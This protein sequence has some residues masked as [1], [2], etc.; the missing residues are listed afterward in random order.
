MKRSPSA[1][2]HIHTPEQV[3]VVVLCVLHMCVWPKHWKTDSDRLGEWS[4]GRH[5]PDTT[6]CFVHLEVY[7]CIQRSGSNLL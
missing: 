3:N 7:K 1:S 6:S 5:G 4:R 2:M